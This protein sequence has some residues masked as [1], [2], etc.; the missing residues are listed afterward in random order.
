MGECWSSGKKSSNDWI[1]LSRCFPG[2]EKNAHFNHC[3]HEITDPVYLPMGY[4]TKLL[5]DLI[6]ER[7]FYHGCRQFSV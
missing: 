2:I 3:A 1:L 5:P 6:T 4:V 7:L